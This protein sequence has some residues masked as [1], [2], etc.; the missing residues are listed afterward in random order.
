MGGEGEHSSKELF[1]QHI[2]SFSGHLHEL[3]TV[4][5]YASFIM[6]ITIQDWNVLTSV[7]GVKKHHIQDSQHCLQNTVQQ[8]CGSMTFWCGSGCGSA[9]PCP[10]ALTNRSGCGSGSC[11]FH[12]WPSRRQQ[13]TNLKKFYC[14]LLLEGTFTSFFKD[15]KSKSHKTVEIKVFLTIFLNDIR[16]QKG[17]KTRGS[18]GSGS[19]SATLVLTFLC[20]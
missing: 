13:K 7:A 10:W 6:W 12:Q 14:I 9:D 4:L 5:S 3:A 11:S 15:K 8:C 1:R 18:G 19:G 16:I 17:P 2:I 20:V